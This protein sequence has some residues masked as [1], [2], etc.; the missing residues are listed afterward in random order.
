MA[1][2]P[3]PYEGSLVQ[4]WLQFCHQGSEI[5]IQGILTQTQLGPPL[6]NLQLQALE[7][8]ESILYAIELQA[9]SNAEP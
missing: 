1:G 9:V 4:R 8:T 7:K 2:A 5:K 6:S 3:Q